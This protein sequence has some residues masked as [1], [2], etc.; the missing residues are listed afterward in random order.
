MIIRLVNMYFKPEKINDFLEV[1]HAS[2]DKI[3]DFKGCRHLELLQ[4]DGDESS[5]MTYSIWDS[6]EDLDQYRHSKLFKETWAKTKVHF[7]AKPEAVSYKR[8]VEV[9]N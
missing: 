7:R 5:L 1:F 6:V 9:G 2:K 3:R 4:V 8:L